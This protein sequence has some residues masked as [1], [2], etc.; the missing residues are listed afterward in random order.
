MI[1]LENDCIYIL[2]EHCEEAEDYSPAYYST[3]EKAFEALTDLADIKGVELLEPAY[4]WQTE[5]YAYDTSD[6]DLKYSIQE[7]ELDW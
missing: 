2:V 3:F 1:R 5:T 6:D 7:V 4:S